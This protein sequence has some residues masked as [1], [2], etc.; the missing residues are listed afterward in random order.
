MNR[1]TRHLASHSQ[2]YQQGLRA[3]ISRQVA[4][5]LSR[6]GKIEQL[7]GPNFKPPKSV[8]INSSVLVDVL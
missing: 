8:K 6:G 1:Y 2:S 5:F 3:E 7:S 4:E